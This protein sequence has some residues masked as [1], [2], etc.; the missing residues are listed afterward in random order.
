MGY[1]E[2]S[3]AYS[4]IVVFWPDHDKRLEEPALGEHCV[5]E[6]HGECFSGII[7][8]EICEAGK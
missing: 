6:T 7:E 5:E 8:G 3:A 2:N 4:T 1:L